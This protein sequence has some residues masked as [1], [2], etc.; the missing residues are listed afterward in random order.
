MTIKYSMKWHCV[1]TNFFFCYLVYTFKKKELTRLISLSS[2]M[3]HFIE[4][5]DEYQSSVSESIDDEDEA[6]IFNNPFLDIEPY[7]LEDPTIN[8]NPGLNE[9]IF[10]FKSSWLDPY[11]YRNRVWC[12][13]IPDDFLPEEK[14]LLILI[15]DLLGI[16][17][18]VPLNHHLLTV[19]CL[20]TGRC[21]ELL[22][23]DKHTFE[24]AYT[25]NFRA[26]LYL[27]TL[28]GEG[29]CCVVPY[30]ILIAIHNTVPF[31]SV[32]VKLKTRKDKKKAEKVTNLEKIFSFANRPIPAQFPLSFDVAFSLSG[33]VTYFPMPDG[34]FWIRVQCG[35]FSISYGDDVSNGKGTIKYPWENRFNGN[36][37]PTLSED[38]INTEAEWMNMEPIEGL[39]INSFAECCQISN[40]DHYQEVFFNV[41]VSLYPE[42]KDAKILSANPKNGRLHESDLHNLTSSDKAI[43]MECNI[44]CPCQRN[45]PCCF[46]NRPCQDLM[47]FYS[48][49]K[50]WGV[51]A[52]KD[53][54]PG[55]FITAYA[56]EIKPDD[57]NSKGE[58]DDN[59]DN[60][61]RYSIQYCDWSPDVEI[62][63]QKKCNIGR[64][65]N[66]SHSKPIVH[67]FLH[68]D[69]LLFSQPDSSA[70]P[71]VSNNL[72][73]P[74]VGIFSNRKIY[75]GEEI[76]LDYGNFYH[77]EK[78]CACNSC[79][80]KNNQLRHIL[81]DIKNSHLPNASNPN[82]TKQKNKNPKE[83]NNNNGNKNTRNGNR[84]KTDTK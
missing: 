62:H 73:V 26:P 21:P 64:F 67:G 10:F 32:K 51:V 69:N 25:V 39:D 17:D 44:K 49:D 41:I 52:T 71:V 11:F 34:N 7:L 79:L 13:L 12:C 33:N 72:E 63:A 82:N 40:P 28:P 18:H 59:R 4:I 75:R 56:G 22:T 74:I 5:D 36:P 84:K 83:S 29:P 80:R 81:E 57:N 20:V 9:L 37:P 66:Q 61:F 24:N 19:F 50:N 31:P 27:D 1:N 76:T 47:M 45:C 54:E 2:M 23:F 8:Q 3:H 43:I 14:G 68:S 46:T 55:V 38:G 70:I 35:S 60:L 58:K 65:I 30:L 77:M 53:I 78:Y 16:P 42:A 48:P 15:Y 6:D